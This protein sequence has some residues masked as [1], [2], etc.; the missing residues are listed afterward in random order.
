MLFVVVGGGGLVG[1]VGVVVCG[2]G[3]VAV[4]VGNC[5]GDCCW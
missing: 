5:C 3:G 2:V 4:V 1:V